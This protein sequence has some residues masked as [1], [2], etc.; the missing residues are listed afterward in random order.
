[1]K[2]TI[3]GAG[4]NIGRR[5]VREAAN[6]GYDLQLITSKDISAFQLDETTNVTTNQIDIQDTKN[7]TSAFSETDVVIS[8]Y[9]PPHDNTN[10]LIDASKSLIE[11]AKNAKA[12]LIAVGGAGSLKV[13][14]D[15]LLIDAPTFPDEYKAIAKSHLAT[16]KELYRPE[17]ELN[18]TNVSPAAY[19]FEGERTGKF[20][21]GDEYLIANEKGESAISME[22]FAVAIL[23]EVENG[24]YIRKRFTVGY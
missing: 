15:L 16:L 14:D 12:R 3:I 13:S 19:I 8:A 7:L 23:D 18:W 21:I 1:M 17:Q 9:A 11:S 24:K 6:R 2:I 4:G 22:D 20:K 10:L 5:I